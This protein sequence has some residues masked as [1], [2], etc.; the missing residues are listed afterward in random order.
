MLVPF[1][2]HFFFP[3]YGGWSFPSWNL[4]CKIIAASKSPSA[5]VWYSYQMDGACRN[6]YLPKAILI[7]PY[8]HQLIKCFEEAGWVLTCI[9]VIPSL[10][11]L[12]NFKDLVLKFGQIIA[13]DMTLLQNMLWKKLFPV[14]KCIHS[15][16][17]CLQKARTYSL[18][19][20]ECPWCMSRGRPSKREQAH[21]YLWLMTKDGWSTFPLN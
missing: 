8:L 12:T 18:W 3:S 2:S 21:Y 7:E 16:T 1:L 4:K 19:Q 17:L 13:L 15:M 11:Q 20:G 14:T 9:V 5:M 10:L 6:T